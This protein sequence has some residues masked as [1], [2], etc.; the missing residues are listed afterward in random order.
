MVTKSTQIL[1]STVLHQRLRQYLTKN[2][3]GVSFW[4]M[5]EASGSTLEEP[6]QGHTGSYNNDYTLDDRPLV[7]SSGFSPRFGGV[8]GHGLASDSAIF[9]GDDGDWS[10]GLWFRVDPGVSS[11]QYLFDA[12]SPSGTV[13]Y[14]YGHSG[15]TAHAY[16]NGSD[17]NFIGGSSNVIAGETYFAS[18]SIDKTNDQI[19]T[20]IDASLNTSDDISSISDISNMD[21]LYIGARSDLNN[22][23]TGH[24]GP[25]FVVAGEAFSATE[26]KRIMDLGNGEVQ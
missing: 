26:Y 11:D 13:Q 14:W 25:C 18:L 15:T 5:D 4:P 3:N 16:V 22:P 21:S 24:L 6:V 10:I 20:Y 9:P 2:W 23:F 17:S 8:S 7:R 12:T 1:K 19:R